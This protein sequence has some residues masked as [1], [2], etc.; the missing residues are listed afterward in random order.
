MH[1]L[2]FSWAFAKKPIA[3]MITSMLMLLL[4]H[5]HA[6]RP[7]RSGALEL[8]P[9]LPLPED[10]CG[11]RLCRQSR[12]PYQRLG[13][14]ALEPMPGFF[15]P[16]DA[17]FQAHLG[18][19]VNDCSGET[20]GS[21]TLLDARLTPWVDPAHPVNGS[22]VFVFLDPVQMWRSQRQHHQGIVC[23]AGA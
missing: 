18:T 5:G 14:F 22:K 21:K 10:A 19:H 12:E 15:L 23:S 1:S 9:S 8:Q 13:Q 2:V 17:N 16:H 6:V 11:G 4:Q 20:D 7:E 3:M